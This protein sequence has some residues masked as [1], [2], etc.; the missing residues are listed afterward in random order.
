MTQADVSAIK[1]HIRN[2]FAA[3]GTLRIVCD[4]YVYRITKDDITSYT[5]DEYGVF[6]EGNIACTYQASCGFKRVYIP[7]G[8]ITAITGKGI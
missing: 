3:E 5:F 8:T 7:F 1:R 2:I 4:K 6:L